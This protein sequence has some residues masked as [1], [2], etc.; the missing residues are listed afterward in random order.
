DDAE[1]VDVIKHQLHS[2]QNKRF[3]L[4]WVNDGEKAL[5]Q[6]R[7]Q[8]NIDL[9]LMD[10]F[11]PD[12][13]GVELTKRISEEKIAVPIIL[14]TS[15]KDFRIAIEAMKYGVEDYLVKEEIVDTIL[16]RT[17]I[18]VLDRSQLSEKITAAEK[19]KL[20]AQKKTE[21]IQELVVTM[22]HE[23]NNPLAAIKISTDILL[24]QKVSPEAQELLAKLNRNISLLEKQIVR[25]R[26]ANAAK[27]SSS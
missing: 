17:I 16:P 19:E 14:L 23:F 6:L 18:N 24:R 11:L 22:C 9:V 20:L 25:L 27:A 13:N 7:S 8:T 21:A 15:N 26:D 10:Y 12:T 5:E 2:F 1:Y 4:T 3:D